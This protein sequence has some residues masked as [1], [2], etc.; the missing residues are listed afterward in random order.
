MLNLETTDKKE[1]KRRTIFIALMVVGGVLLA[2]ALAFGIHL[3]LQAVEND[4]QAREKAAE[5]ARIQ[6]IQE[7]AA[8]EQRQKESEERRNTALA[9]IHFTSDP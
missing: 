8:E 2:V 1:Y 6:Q 9:S 4:E 7:Q 5:Q 3:H